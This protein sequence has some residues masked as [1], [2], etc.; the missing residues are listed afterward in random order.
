MFRK[1]LE[2]ENLKVVKEQNYLIHLSLL[3]D[4]P[5]DDIAR[6]VRLYQVGWSQVGHPAQQVER[7]VPHRHQRVLAE[8]DR[9]GAMRGFC[10]LCKNN[11]GHASVYE[12]PNDALDTHHHDGNWALR[13]RLSAPIPGIRGS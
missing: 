6:D 2:G 9:L 3:G 4:L 11:S 12:N 5:P 1:F 8:Q 13:S 7:P 10:E